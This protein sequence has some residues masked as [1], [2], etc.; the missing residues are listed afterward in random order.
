MYVGEGGRG[1]GVNL[2]GFL[3]QGPGRDMR[4]ATAA[5]RHCSDAACC[6]AGAKKKKREK[7]IIAAFTDAEPA[8][9]R[10]SSTATPMND[11]DAGSSS[12]S[13]SGGN[14]SGALTTVPAPATRIILFNCLC[15]IEVGITQNV[16]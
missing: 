2:P 11:T 12:S 15:C 3:H 13:G 14:I 7:M 5:S 6:L 16:L 9:V 1:L 4:Y 10:T 8:E